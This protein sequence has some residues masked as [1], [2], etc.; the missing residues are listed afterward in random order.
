MCWINVAKLVLHILVLVDSD[1]DVD[2]LVTNGNKATEVNCHAHIVVIS[3][4][5]LM[6]GVLLRGWTRGGGK[7]AFSVAKRVIA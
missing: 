2:A 4:D 3:L 1:R 7:W 5:D 6:L